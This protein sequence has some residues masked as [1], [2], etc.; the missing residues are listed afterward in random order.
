MSAASHDGA[1]T[2]SAFPMLWIAFFFVGFSPGA[3]VPALT[4]MLTAHGMAEWVPMAFLMPPLCA[5]ISPLIGGALADQQIAAE[6]LTAW[7]SLISGMLLFAAFLTIDAGWHP[8]WFIGLLGAQ[9]LV[10]G[11]LWGLLATISLA[12]LRD[13]EKR[14]PLVRLGGTLG[15]M[16]G[17]IVTSY[18]L[19]ADQGTTAGYAG[20][21]AKILG[22]CLA[23]R[24]PHTPPT[25]VARSWT[26]R[27]GFDAFRLLRER[28]HLV[29]FSVTALF[30]VPLTAFYMYAPEFLSDLGNETPAGTMTIAQF[31]EIGAMLAVGG[32]MVRWR[33]KTLLSF[34]LTLS[35]LRYAFSTWA[36]ETGQILW[37]VLGVSLH[38]VTYTLYFITAQVFLD[39]RVGT[40]LKAQAQGLLAL[41]SGGIGPLIGALLC[42]WLRERFVLDGEGWAM[43]WGVL[44]GIILLCL[45]GFVIF[46]QGMPRTESG[47]LASQTD[48]GD[49]G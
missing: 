43:F 40:G 13:G 11:P 1:E 49:H 22:G 15:W 7:S 30:S 25:G 14:F 2:R 20:A 21:I 28:D 38:G 17:G 18:V 42:G 12:T 29:F 23:F 24:L 31:L 9:A 16:A 27:L 39:R 48:G 4:N 37:H 35:A 45:A 47:D 41:V 6:R 46:Y 5:L 19:L 26:S 36:G 32:L 34:A 10:G 44:T 3:W 8:A 33:V